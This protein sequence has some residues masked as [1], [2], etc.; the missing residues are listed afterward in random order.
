MIQVKKKNG[1]CSISVESDMTIYEAQE[2]SAR[3]KQ[4]IDACKKIELNLQSV[5]EIDTAGVQILL[6]TKRAAVNHDKEFHIT[7]HS[8][9][10][11]QV[12]QMLNIAH[13]F[14]DPIVI[15]KQ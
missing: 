6:A 10:V 9:A 2:I 5:S 13:E 15:S 1:Q 11:V 4:Q 12:F 14:G 3:L 8:E 7:S